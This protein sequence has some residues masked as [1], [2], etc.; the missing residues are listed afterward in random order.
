MLNRFEARGY[1]NLA[2][3]V[4]LGRCTALVGPNNCGKSNL[5]RAIQFLADAML[6][7]VTEWGGVIKLHGG[8]QLAARRKGFPPRVEKVE[9]AWNYGGP[10]RVAL[11]LQM[12]KLQIDNT[13]ITEVVSTVAADGAERRFDTASGSGPS[14]LLNWEMDWAI[15]TLVYDPLEWVHLSLAQVSPR[16]LATPWTG[17]E[18]A[19][20][21]LPD[22]SNLAAHL[23]HLENTFPAGIT[24]I[25]E[26]MREFL[27]TLQRI[28]VKSPEGA[29]ATWIEFVDADQTVR[30]LRELSDGTV[31]VLLLATLLHGPKRSTLLMLDEPELNLHPAWLKV[32]ARWLQAPTAVD[33]VLFSTH[34]TDLLDAMTEGYRRG[35][36]TLLVADRAAGFVNVDRAK[37]QTFFDQ[38]YELGDLYRV[39]EPELG[40]WPW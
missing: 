21:L 13:V 1:R 7:S 8:H 22:A 36:V 32:I 37:V 11:G 30:A 16:Q 35:E 19:E 9:L 14:P 3:E 38:G 27:P 25:T 26:V 5:M 31:V 40:G 34:S 10:T 17:E 18:R 28:W 20:R 23:K 33:Q 39:G 12:D 4:E 15:M 6:P 2:T 29:G 24:R